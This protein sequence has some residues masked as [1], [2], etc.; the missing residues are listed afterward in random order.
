MVL[1]YVRVMCLVFDCKWTVVLNCSSG[2][3]L[4]LVEVRLLWTGWLYCVVAVDAS[5]LEFG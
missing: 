4:V 2:W 5:C 1:V 3:S